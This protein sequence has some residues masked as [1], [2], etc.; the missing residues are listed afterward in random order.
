MSSFASNN[1][2]VFELKE[3]HEKYPRYLCTVQNLKQPFHPLQH[4]LEYE[5]QLLLTCSC[6][7]LSLAFHITYST[8]YNLPFDHDYHT[9]MLLLVAHKVF[10][11]SS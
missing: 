9:I 11:L 2:F 6:K 10:Q 7:V 5:I 8:T 1:L 4:I 3:R